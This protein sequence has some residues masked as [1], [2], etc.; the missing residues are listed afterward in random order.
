MTV[1]V[2]NR[3]TLALV[4]TPVTPVYEGSP[5]FDL[6]CSATGAPEGSDYV[7]EWTPRGGTANTDLLIAGTDGPT[8]TFDVPESVDADTDYEYTLTVS[9]RGADP[10]TANVTVQVLKK[11]SLALVC[12]P[13]A[14]VYEGAPDFDLNC[15]AS[16]APAGSTYDYVWTARGSTV[17]PGQLSSTTVANPTFDVPEEVSSDT[18][19]EYTLTVSAEN[20]D[21]CG[22]G[23]YRD[24]AEQES[25]ECCVRN[26]FS[27]V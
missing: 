9:A 27:G 24:G 12:T 14:P 15:A 2:L 10:E 16:G 5:D 1:R 20:A 23:R 3:A 19:Y 25:V 18:D 21:R 4:C 13:V 17:V 26:A 8:P 22:R 6:N 11:P 7:Y